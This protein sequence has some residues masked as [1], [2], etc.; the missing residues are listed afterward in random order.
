MQGQ[1]PSHD[2][3]SEQ[4]AVGQLSEPMG[5]VPSRTDPEDISTVD[6]G[7]IGQCQVVGPQADLVQREA[8]A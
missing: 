8:K 4:Q 6:G 2:L 5:S 7:V 1:E 3:L